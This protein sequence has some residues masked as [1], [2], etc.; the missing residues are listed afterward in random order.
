M[1]AHHRIEDVRLMNRLDHA[2]AA[3]FDELRGGV[4]LERGVERQRGIPGPN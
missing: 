2:S 3:L 1:S 4:L